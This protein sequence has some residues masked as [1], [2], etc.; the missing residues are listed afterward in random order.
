[1][2]PSPVALRHKQQAI[3]A[4]RRDQEQLVKEGRAA[5]LPRRHED[6]FAAA[7]TIQEKQDQQELQRQEQVQENHRK[8]LAQWRA[9]RGED[10]QEPGAL[11][12]AVQRL[13]HPD[14]V[15][16]NCRLQGA[17]QTIDQAF[18]P[19][20]TSGA[21]DPKTNEY[22]QFCDYAYLNDPYKYTMTGDKLYRFF[23][24]QAFRTKRNIATEPDPET[25]KKKKRKRVKGEYF[26]PME[27]EAIMLQYS[28]SSKSYPIPEHPVGFQSFDQ[29]KAAVKQIHGNQLERGASG[30]PWELIWTTNCKKLHRHVKQR[31]PL[32]K[33]LNY[34]EKVDSEFAAYTVVERYEE[35]E[36]EFW[37]DSI[38]A[39]GRRST[40]T[41]LRHRTCMLYLTTGIL[42][43]ESL[44]RAELSDFCAVKPPK[45]ESDVHQML[46]MVTQLPFG[47]TNHGRKL[48]GRATRHKN[49]HLCAVGS[50]ALYLQYRF[51]CSGEFTSMKA[52]DWANPRKWFD[53]KFLVDLNGKDNT[54]EMY[55][56]SYGKH[57]KAILKKLNIVCNKLLHLGRH[58]GA[59]TLELLEEES[60][61]IRRMGQWNPSMQ[62]NHYSAKLP[63]SP[64]QKLAGY[65]SQVKMYFNTRT[66][67]IPSQELLSMTPIG[68]W[69]YDAFAAVMELE[70]EHP[71]ALSF[72]QFMNELNVVFLQDAAVL[73]LTGR[74][75]PIFSELPV[76]LT[77]EYKA[78]AVYHWFCYN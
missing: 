5:C 44:H 24:Y 73:Q 54:K 72:L 35:I 33:K 75:H 71:T 63:M 68:H 11:T 41:H 21:I 48:Y 38:S 18:R 22:F 8:R 61:E 50:V 2:A 30:T 6:A 32:V 37:N 14:D 47:K 45:L 3:Q 49:A 43:S 10:E 46:L 36:I 65:N 34:C 60:E 76:C 25:G 58:V 12:E 23:F 28:Q 57:V 19:A 17:V 66:T 77:D 27:Y 20:K 42:R 9:E 67:I 70:T 59:R 31:V 69:S 26:N 40:L 4:S 1:M 74:D 62:D 55:N 13:R 39:L 64:I 16:L 53:V 15:D 56:D 51:W 7:D 52:E 29:Y 78:S